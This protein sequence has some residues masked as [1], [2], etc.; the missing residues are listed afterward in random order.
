MK[1]IT[2]SQCD[3]REIQLKPLMSLLLW[4]DEPHWTP[5]M[6]L[7]DH[8]YA[9]RHNSPRAS[10]LAKKKSVKRPRVIHIVLEDGTG[11]GPSVEPMFCFLKVCLDMIGVLLLHY[12]WLDDKKYRKSVNNLCFKRSLC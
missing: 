3:N 8:Q 5:K 9:G 1:N 4:C 12:L 11:K 6:P 2:F 7:Q 10:S